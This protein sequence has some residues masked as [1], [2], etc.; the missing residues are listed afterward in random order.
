M[1]MGLYLRLQVG[2]I[3]IGVQPPILQYYLAK[4]RSFFLNQ[5]MAVIMYLSRCSNSG[6]G[7]VGLHNRHE[8]LGYPYAKTTEMDTTDRKYV[9]T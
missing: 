9:G 7:F 6:G 1:Q 2:S 4:S 8:Q 3:G 5:Q